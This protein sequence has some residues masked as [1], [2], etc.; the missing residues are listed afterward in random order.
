MNIQEQRRRAL[1][2]LQQR[3]GNQQ[4]LHIDYVIDDECRREMN[5]PARPSHALPYVGWLVGGKI[6][7]TTPTKAS[8]KGIELIKRW[9]GLR[10]NA[11]QCPAK[12]WTIGYGHTRGVKP[13]MMIS[14]QHA[15]DLLLEDLM[16]YEE[17][18]RELV[19]VPLSQ[20]QFDALVSFSFNVGVGALASSTLL[21]K[22]N[23]G[24]YREAVA[25]LHRWNKA[26][27]TVLPGL[28]ERRN[29]EHALFEGE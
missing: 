6:A 21:R 16:E 29:D 25:E 26:G 11:Y 10:T 4:C 20:G 14:H 5:L 8:A 28:V 15:E 19:K 12:V 22:L 24:Q 9:E 1:E 18:V 13:D 23:Q 2:V 27:K 17:A 3:R 7:S